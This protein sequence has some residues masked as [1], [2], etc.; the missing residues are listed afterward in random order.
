MSVRN[1]D[2]RVPAAPGVGAW[3]AVPADAWRPPRDA[4]SA[5]DADPEGEMPLPLDGWVEKELNDAAGFLFDYDFI[6]I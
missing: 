6:G 3:D 1:F 4:S 5:P 2:V